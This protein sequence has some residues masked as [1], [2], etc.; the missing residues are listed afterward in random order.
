MEV[1]IIKRIRG[2]VKFSGLEALKDQLRKDR[3]A[4]IRI[5]S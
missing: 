2:E 5:L 1:S 3:E 4:V